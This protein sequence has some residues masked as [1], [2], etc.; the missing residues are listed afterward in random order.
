MRAELVPEI[1][2]RWAPA[3]ANAY[4]ALEA[5][6]GPSEVAAGL[7]E[8]GIA[9]TPEWLAGVFGSLSPADAAVSAYVDAHAEEIAALDPSRAELIEIV[10]EIVTPHSGDRRYTDWWLAVFQAHVPHPRSSDLIFS[11]PAN[12]SSADWSPLR[13]VDEALAYRPFA[14]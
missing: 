1:D 2:A 8:V 11:P 4:G 10:C 5:G 13:I 7:V 14:L 9:V 3:L 6:H 12:V